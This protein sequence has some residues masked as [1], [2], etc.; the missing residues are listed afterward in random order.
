MLKR[1]FATPKRVGR[2]SGNDARPSKQTDSPDALTELEAVEIG[3]KTY[4]QGLDAIGRG[5][6]SLAVQLFQRVASRHPDIGWFSYRLG[7]V[8]AAQGQF[9]E[10]DRIFAKGHRMRLAPHL[11]TDSR[12]LMVGSKHHASL[13]E[14]AVSDHSCVLDL[15]IAQSDAAALL[16]L[17]CD[18]RYFNLYAA[19]AIASAMANGDVALACHVHV[20]NPDGEV[21]DWETK[22]RARHPGRTIGFSH[23][24]TDLSSHGE[25]EQKVYYSCRRFQLAPAI[26]RRARC[27]IVIAD[28]DQLVVRSLGTVVSSVDD[29][30]V[31]LI[32][33]D[34]LSQYNPLA[35]ISASALVTHDGPGARAYFDLVTAYIDHCLAH[36]LW[37]WHLDQA[38]LYGAFTMLQASG[39]QTR[40]RSLEPSILESIALDGRPNARPAPSTVFWSATSSRVDQATKRSLEFL[41]RHCDC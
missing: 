25:A 2:L 1:L 34:G 41:T 16:F 40:F 12:I 8:L 36:D 32:M 13:A 37:I 20:I 24:T 15:S 7:G 27:P 22:I 30:D 5:D 17:C 21:L 14:R 10:A 11:V 28:I 18:A 35:K 4:R 38:A 9:D 23:E 6:L 33:P 3:G 31:A 19:A 29:D 39:Q 26:L